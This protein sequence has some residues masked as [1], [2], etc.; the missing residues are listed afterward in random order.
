MIV[1]GVVKNTAFIK[2]DDIKRIN[3]QMFR[4]FAQAVKI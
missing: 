1:K 4:Y 2:V 3:L